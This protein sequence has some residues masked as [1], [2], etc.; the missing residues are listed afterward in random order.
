MQRRKTLKKKISE[1]LNNARKTFGNYLHFDANNY[2]P[3]DP[4]EE[5]VKE[6]LKEK[7]EERFPN[8]LGDK[9]ETLDLKLSKNNR[10]K[11]PKPPQKIVKQN[12]KDS[13]SDFSQNNP[14]Q[15]WNIKPKKR[16]STN[17]ISMIFIILW[18]FRAWTEFTGARRRRIY[19]SKEK[20]Y[21]RFEYGKLLI[22]W[23]SKETKGNR[24]YYEAKS[25][26][27]DKEG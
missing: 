13:V 5:E 25:G 17:Q 23:S 15:K 18:Y 20:E 7:V 12:S 19:F 24:E 22:F 6:D 26:E 2:H 8:N 16:F 11:I 9:S 4:I 10:S 3:K 1:E 27:I 14:P 21:L